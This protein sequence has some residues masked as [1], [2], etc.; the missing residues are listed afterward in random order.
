MSLSYTDLDEWMGQRN[1]KIETVEVDYDDNSFKLEYVPFQPVN[2]ALDE[3][4]IE[5]GYHYP[6][7]PVHY[8]QIL[9]LKDFA[10]IT[11]R[12]HEKLDFSEYLRFIDFLLANF[13]TF[14]DGACKPSFRDMGGIIR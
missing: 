2:A 3:V 13:L 1:F 4:D 9:R 12:G 10:R 5:F 6:F 7:V 11:I 14:S 8:C